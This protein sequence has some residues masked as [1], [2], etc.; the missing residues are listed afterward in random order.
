VF[1]LLMAAACAYYYWE[2]GYLT[3]DAA[4]L[5][6]FA[7]TV[8]ISM[9]I[10]R[11]KSRRLRERMES[12][13]IVYER[14]EWIRT[15]SSFMLGSLFQLLLLQADILV[16]GYLANHTQAGYYA[17]AVR[18]TSLV[19]F[20]LSETDYVYLPP[21]RDAIRQG[22][23]KS[24]QKLVTDASRQILLMALPLLLLLVLT[25]SYLLGGFGK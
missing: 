15:A 2:H 5:Q 3:V 16:I 24:L 20:G 18:I 10:R 12:S 13:E 25:G 4:L 23:K 6:Q 7:C 14:A 11:A 19:V 1:Q 22:Q 21:I 8:I 9:M 17:V